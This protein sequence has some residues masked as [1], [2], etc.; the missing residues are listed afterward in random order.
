MVYSSQV[1]TFGTHIHTLLCCSSF[2]FLSPLIAFLFPHVFKTFTRSLSLLHIY[3]CLLG[4]GLRKRSKAV[5]V[6]LV[7]GQLLLIMFQH[8]MYEVKEW[9]FSALN[10]ILMGLWALW[11]SVTIFFT[12]RSLKAEDEAEAM[13]ELQDGNLQ[14]NLRWAIPLKQR[15]FTMVR[16]TFHE[17]LF[18]HFHMFICIYCIFK[19]YK[20]CFFF[21]F[22]KNS[23]SPPPP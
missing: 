15:V 5:A 22:L 9:L 19:R 16:D 21:C 7:G 20:N 17:S 6:I 12:W 4:E 18:K 10:V 8:E 1:C 11:L 23:Q 14:L 3:T 13:A 2:S